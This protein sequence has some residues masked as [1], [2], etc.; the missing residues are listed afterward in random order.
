[1]SHRAAGREAKRNSFADV[2]KVAQLLANGGRCAVC[3]YVYRKAR[4]LEYGR[5]NGSEHRYYH[6]QHVPLLEPLLAGFPPGDI[7]VDRK[8]PSWLHRLVYQRACY[9]RRQE[10]Y[11]FTQW[12]EEQGLADNDDEKNIHA[13]LLVEPTQL[14]IGAAS[15]S[16]ILW[17]ETYGAFTV[18]PPWSDDMWAF[19]RRVGPPDPRQAQHLKERD[20]RKDTA[21]SRSL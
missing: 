19:L 20:E 1:M 3:G 5:H 4:D 21:P 2:P 8:S 11:D 17:K 10:E 18:E 15:F 7:R 13:L 14:I 9:L 12:D 6:R 16:W